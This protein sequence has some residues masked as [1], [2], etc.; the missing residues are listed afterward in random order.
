MYRTFLILIVAY[1]VLAGGAVAIMFANG[2]FAA[3]SDSADPARIARGETVY[4][5]HCAACHGG[6]LEG[7]PDWQNQRADGTY[8]APPQDHSGHTW[9]HSDAQLFEYIKD[10]GARFERRAFKSAMPGLGEAL[11]S[12][13]IWAVIAFVK[14]RWPKQFRAKQ[15]RANFL[16]GLHNH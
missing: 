4:M 14:S 8:P 16:G 10:G 11:D 3:R 6:D 5:E 13:E 15:A 1:L 7:Q 2:V 12:A 9:E